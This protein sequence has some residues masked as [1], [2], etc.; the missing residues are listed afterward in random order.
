MVQNSINFNGEDNDVTNT[1][2]KIR[3]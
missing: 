3:K 2:I 1:G